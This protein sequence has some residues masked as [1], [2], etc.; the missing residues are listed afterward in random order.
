[1]FR[2]LEILLDSD[3]SKAAAGILDIHPKTLAFRRKRIEELLGIPLDHP[4]ERMKLSIAVAL[5]KLID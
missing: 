2:T 3:C 5:Q 1:M 4:Q